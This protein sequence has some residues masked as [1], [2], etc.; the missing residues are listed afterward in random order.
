MVDTHGQ[1]RSGW[2]GVDL[3]GTLAHYEG[4]KGID[5]IGEPIP[6]MVDRV[7]AWLAEGIEVK[8]V[9]ARVA[10]DDEEY[11][12]EILKHICAWCEKHIGQVL[13]VTNEK[14]MCMVQLWDDRC[15]QVI[16]NTGERADDPG[17]WREGLARYAHDAWS[18]WMNYLFSKSNLND[19]GTVTIP[20]WAV[21]RWQGQI[22]TR[23]WDLS[24]EEKKSDQ[25]EADKI[26]SIIKGEQ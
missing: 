15:V 2:I 20:K 23:Y 6:K 18:G 12:L 3:D 24:E 13:V 8:I 21:V 19:D 4:W 26:I 22:K 16:P 17:K 25:D 11:A 1:N 9:T 14:D 10:V 5:H 7:K